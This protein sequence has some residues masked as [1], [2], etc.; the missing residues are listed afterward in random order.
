M[1]HKEQSVGEE[2][3]SGGEQ[4]VVPVDGEG[5]GALGLT[6]GSEVER[7]VASLAELEF[8]AELKELSLLGC[9]GGHA[10]DVEELEIADVVPG[11]DALV[12]GDLLEELH[13]WRK[14][15]GGSELVLGFA[16]A[17]EEARAGEGCI[18]VAGEPPA[19]LGG[20]SPGGKQGGEI[21]GFDGEKRALWD[22]GG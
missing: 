9:G 2:V 21:V 6:L 18:A 22:K 20:G 12:T 17:G 1:L 8:A 3:F 13:V 5:D 15:S 19:L 4:E 14:S 11:E 10:S 16:E 7:I